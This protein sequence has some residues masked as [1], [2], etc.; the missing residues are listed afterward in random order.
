MA[1]LEGIFSGGATPA[2]ER[3]IS[4]AGARH[5]LILDN[6]ANA[7]TPGYRRKDLDVGAFRESLRAACGASGGGEPAPAAGPWPEAR[8]DR[9]GAAGEL[10]REGILRHDGNDVNVEME[11]AILSK[12]ASYHNQMAALLRKSFEMVK[13]AI[14]ERV[15][16][17]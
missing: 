15:P 10:P 7:D 17:G 6:I 2:L 16:A 4:F 13:A 5:R 14:S 12:N 8:L 3:A 11:L 9:R 1:W